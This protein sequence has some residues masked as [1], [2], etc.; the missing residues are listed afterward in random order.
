MEQSEIGRAKECPTRSGNVLPHVSCCFRTSALTMEEK[1]MPRVSSR[2]THDRINCSGVNVESLGTT[3][4]ETLQRAP[5]LRQPEL[6]QAV[7]NGFN[8]FRALVRSRPTA[9]KAKSAMM[10][11]LGTKTFVLPKL[12]RSLS[13][14]WP[15][16]RLK[17]GLRDLSGS[18]V[19]QKQLAVA[20]RR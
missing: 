5:L 12:G 2:S 15:T 18:P 3:P 9:F 10:W 20:L 1:D 14:M 13:V 19:F 6:A 4:S 8:T 16:F 11:R 17:L 7:S